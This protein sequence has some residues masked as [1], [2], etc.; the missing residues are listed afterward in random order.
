MRL[1]ELLVNR[2]EHEVAKLFSS[3][4]ACLEFLAEA[5]WQDGYACRKCGYNNY[6]QGKT[7]YSRRCTKCKHNESA[8]ANT[9]FHGCKMPLNLAFRMAYKICCEP[10]I[11]TYK[12]SDLHHTR[13]MTCWKLKKKILECIEIQQNLRVQI[14]PV[15]PI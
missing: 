9:P 4:E 6:C 8:T 14:Y 10:G 1:K 2:P 3:Q 13:Q 11:S 12:L 15:V 5:K 7:L